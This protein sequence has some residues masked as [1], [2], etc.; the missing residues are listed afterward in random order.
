MA[1]EAQEWNLPPAGG[2]AHWELVSTDTAA[3][4]NFHEEIFGWTFEH[5]ET[6][7]HWMF[8]AP[9]GINGGLRNPMNEAGEGPNHSN[10]VMVNSIEETLEKAS[11]AGAQVVQPKMEVGAFGHMAAFI[12]P[13]GLP[14]TIWEAK[15]PQA[16]EE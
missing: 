1:D 10:H 3:T 8:Q 9:G 12:G 15:T 11:A 6:Q 16:E 13:G 2:L 7:D 4:K 14:Q 5:E